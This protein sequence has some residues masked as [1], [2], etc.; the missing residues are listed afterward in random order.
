MVESVSPQLNI[1]AIA[2]RGY[3]GVLLDSIKDDVYCPGVDAYI[4]SIGGE[5]GES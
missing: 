2:V 4:L 5:A 3:L 1:E